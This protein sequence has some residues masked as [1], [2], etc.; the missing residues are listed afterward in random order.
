MNDAKMAVWTILIEEH[1]LSLV[2]TVLRLECAEVD[3]IFDTADRDV[4]E[5]P[6]VLT[7]DEQPVV[8][9]QAG[10]PQEALDVG[11]VND[12]RLHAGASDEW[13]C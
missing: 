7:R 13:S 4:K 6:K 8:L 10:A 12:P 11:P 2:Q 1:S 9:Q 3:D 5:Q